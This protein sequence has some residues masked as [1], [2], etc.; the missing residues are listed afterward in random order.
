MMGKGAVYTSNYKGAT[1]GK[2]NFDPHTLIPQL[3]LRATET[4]QSIPDKDKDTASTRAVL[5]S[6]CSVCTKERAVAREHDGIVRHLIVQPRLRD[7][8]DVWQTRTAFHDRL[9]ELC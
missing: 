3:K 1:T 6:S 4:T 7:S 2:Q 9:L 5:V 8:D